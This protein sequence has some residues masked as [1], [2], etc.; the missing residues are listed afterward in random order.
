MASKPAENA[1]S[2]EQVALRRLANSLQTAIDNPADTK[3]PKHYK[4][5]FLDGLKVAAKA[6]NELADDWGRTWP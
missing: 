3:M 2:P 5:G 1:A 4:D 6:A